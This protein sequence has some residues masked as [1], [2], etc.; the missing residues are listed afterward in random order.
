LR[1]WKKQSQLVQ[2][3]LLD[4]RARAQPLDEALQRV[5]GARALDP[6]NA[7]TYYLLGEILYLKADYSGVESALRKAISIDPQLTAATITLVSQR[8]A[9]L[10]AGDQSWSRF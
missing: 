8:H 9:L 10:E 5:N 7:I 4:R 2:P 3:K 6:L 1:Q